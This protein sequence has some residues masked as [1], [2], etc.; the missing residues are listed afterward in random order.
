MNN[1]NLLSPV[2]LESK[3]RLYK[4]ISC[5]SFD[6]LYEAES[7]D[8]SEIKSLV[9]VVSIPA[10][11]NSYDIFK[12]KNPHLTDIEI[13]EHYASIVNE[14]IEAVVVVSELKE[15]QNIVKCRKFSISKRMDYPGWD[16]Y[17]LMEYLTPM[18]EYFSRNLTQAKVIRLGIDICNAL[19]VCHN[20][21]IIHGD[22]KPSNIFVTSD[23]RFKIADFK[24]N[25][26]LKKSTSTL[27]S[28]Q[29]YTFTSPEVYGGHGGNNMSDIYSLGIVMYKLLNNNFEPFRESNDITSVKNAFDMRMNGN[30]IS[31]P[32]NAEP[33]L[34]EI[35]IK[36]CAYS[37][38]D[39]YKTAADMKKRLESLIDG[40]YITDSYGK[41][42]N[43][44]K[45][46]ANLSLKEDVMKVKTDS[47]KTIARHVRKRRILLAAI[48]SSFLFIALCCTGAYL[49]FENIYRTSKY[50]ISQNEFDNAREELRTIINYKDSRELL[51]KCDYFEGEYYVSTGEIERALKIFKNLSDRGYSD[52]FDKYVHCILIKADMYN[53]S[54]EPEK[55]LEILSDIN[56]K[57]NS[58]N[59]AH[60]NKCK[61]TSAMQLYNAKKY[62]LACRVFEE[63]KDKQMISESKYRL[64]FQYKKNKDYAEAMCLFSQL[65][66]YSDSTEQFK[67]VE[68]LIMENNSQEDF[69]SSYGELNGKYVNSDGYYIQYVTDSH[70]KTT[71]KYNLPHTKGTYFKV[72]DGVHYHKSEGRS[73]SKQWIFHKV[74]HGK[75]K[76]YNYIDSRVYILE[77]E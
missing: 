17:I 60:I 11:K 7:I 27:Y 73:W 37:S 8:N 29:S 15:S 25:G 52:A 38:K 10:D 12:E 74:S 69:N 2:P 76:V 57:D 70:N 65:K 31:A 9:K 33:R 66:K 55:A 53:A 5:S 62:K 4:Q 35:V 44:A 67:A 51:M 45:E 41:K 24:I 58:A 30:R 49:Y 34:S 47:K 16:I 23:G 3:W 48:I 50:L 64:A 18:T 6:K 63:I 61:H 56:V 42:S 39:R 59:S 1:N 28:H 54:K 19:E 20:S 71:T 36:A 72:A 77:E 21:D 68:K 43:F 75:Y 46:K 22:V 26:I 13:L 40:T 14:Y 32:A